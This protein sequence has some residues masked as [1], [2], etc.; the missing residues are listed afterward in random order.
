MD[1]F[2]LAIF[3]D[4]YYCIHNDNEIDG[5]LSEVMADDKPC[6]CE[7][8]CSRQFDEIPKTLTVANPDGTFSSMKLENLYPFVDPEEQKENMPNWW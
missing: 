4:T 5:V 3:L 6:L 1:G 8:V 7:I 2:T